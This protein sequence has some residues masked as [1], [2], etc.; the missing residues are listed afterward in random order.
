MRVVQI[1]DGLHSH[2]GAERL[3]ILFAETAVD[4]DVELTVITLRE[5]DPAVLKELESLGV[6]VISFPARR[7]WS[8]RRAIAL[9]R[10]LRSE[11]FDVVHTHLV[12]A[13]VLGV[14]A[15]CLKAV[16]PGVRP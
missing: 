2:G 1:I 12:R 4:S 7:F 16:F 13:T 10:F 11:P 9:L 6:R 15:D 8:P 3:Q 14:L 5:S